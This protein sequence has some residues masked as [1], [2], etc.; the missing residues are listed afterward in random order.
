MNE[1]TDTLEIMALDE[2]DIRHFEKQKK[3]IH[4]ITAIIGVI[5]EVI[6]FL[7]VRQQLTRSRGST[8]PVFFIVTGTILLLGI[9][10][11]LVYNR[12][13]NKIMEANEKYVFKGI[14]TGKRRKFKRR[15][16]YYFFDTPKITFEVDFQQFGDFQ[17]RE[18]IEAHIIIT[19]PIFP[20]FPTNKETGKY[21]KAFRIESR[22]TS[23]Y[24]QP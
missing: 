20:H 21:H 8:L 2:E 15:Q 5:M 14:I 12:H 7:S 17:E 13:H 3:M 1:N 18:P 4:I 10:V 11:I 23:L 19:D 22:E 6:L 16:P 24:N 9:I